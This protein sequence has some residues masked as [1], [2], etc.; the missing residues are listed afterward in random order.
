MLLYI[1]SLTPSPTRQ[2]ERCSLLYG[3]M[4]SIYLNYLHL[5]HVRLDE[6]R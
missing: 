1:R 3:Y 6:Y 5:I 4:R 2:F